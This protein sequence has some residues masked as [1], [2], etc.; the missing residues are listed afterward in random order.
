M[1]SAQHLRGDEPVRTINMSPE[2]EQAFT[3]PGLVIGLTIRIDHKRM[4]R[5]LA[6]LD[7]VILEPVRRR[8]MMVWRRAIVCRRSALEVLHVLSFAVSQRGA[9]A[10]IGS[11]A[12]MPV[13][14][15]TWIS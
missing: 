12:E 15:P 4:Q 6:A 7:T 14:E 1:V 10:A 3:L 8:V 9:R 11:A 13:S 5:C 2:G